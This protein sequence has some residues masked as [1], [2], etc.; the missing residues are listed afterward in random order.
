MSSDHHLTRGSGGTLGILR[1]RVAQKPS[2][3]WTGRSSEMR[4]R[5][6]VSSGVGSSIAAKLP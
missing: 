3:L 5:M 1:P 6:S 2:R 4:A